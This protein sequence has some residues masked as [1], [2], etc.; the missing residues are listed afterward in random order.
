MRL[1]KELVIVFLLCLSVASA[2]FNVN[3]G[4]AVDVTSNCGDLECF[5]ENFNACTRAILTVKQTDTET[6]QYTIIGSEDDL[7][8]VKLKVTA[9]SDRGWYGKDMNCLYDN[10]QDFEAVKDDFSQCTGGLYNLIV[11]EEVVEEEEKAVEEVVEEPKVEE[12]KQTIKTVSLCQGCM[13]GGSC[14]EVGVQKQKSLGGMIYYCNAEYVAQPVKSIGELC[15]SDYECEFFFCDNGVCN[16]IM[17][18]QGLDK[19]LIGVLVG[20]I[21]VLGGLI[22]LL[23]KFGIGFKKIEKEEE[24][25]EKKE[26]NKPMWQP[27]TKDIKQRPYDYKPKFDVLEKKLGKTFKKK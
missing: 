7:C 14:V 21:V 16:A 19:I 17:E 1:V 8:E 11:P 13:I 20:V 27:S 22:F 15:V 5:K 10:S 4:E 6:F 12:K 25:I 26:K 3:L 24:K 18:E 9:H 23:Y 2:E